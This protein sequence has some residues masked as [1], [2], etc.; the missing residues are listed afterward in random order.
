MARGFIISGESMVTVKG[1]SDSLVIA[2]LAQLGLT[3][4]AITVGL[5]FT[6]EAV[7]VDAWKETDVQTFLYAANIS[8]NM[9]HFDEAVLEE[10][11]RLSAGSATV[12][13]A[14]SRMGTLLG[15]GAARFVPPNNYIG[16][17]I[18]SPVAALPWRFFYARLTTNPISYPLGT[19]KSVVSLNWRA[20]A[21][22]NDPWGGG[23]AQ[24]TTTAGTGCVDLRP[25][26]RFLIQ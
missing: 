11:V 18:A 14:T 13:G 25:W 7:D 19:R 15:G 23:S 21:Y 22:T 26:K 1:R 3:V 12:F 24:P 8:M 20:I 10:C 2:N 6:Q 17:N 5:E 9:I 16:L 4:D